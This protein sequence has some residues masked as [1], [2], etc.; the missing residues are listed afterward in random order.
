[1]DGAVLYNS[2]SNI[3]ESGFLSFDYWL[4]KDKN[5]QINHRYADELA[6]FK[7]NQTGLFTSYQISPQWSAAA[8]YH[9]NLETDVNLDA[10]IGIEYRSCCWSIQLAAQRQVVVD[11]NQT[12][13][14]NEDAVQY[15]NGISLNFKISG[16]GGDISSSI[17]DLFSSSI[18]AY[19]R[20]YLI[21]N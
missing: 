17:A 15:D 7:I 18:F 13:F 16:M 20:P 4:T 5:F 21:T 2:D 10:L 9:Y 12:E 11:L 8:S 1:M 3:V 14:N 19:R 6:G